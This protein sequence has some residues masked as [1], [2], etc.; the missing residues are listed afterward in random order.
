MAPKRNSLNILAIRFSAIGDVA[1]TVPV[2]D[3]FARQYPQHRITFLS[4]PRFEPFFKSMPANFIFLGADVK[5]EYKGNAGLRRLIGELCQRD[6]DLVLDLHGVLRSERIGL[7]MFLHGVRIKRIRKDRLARK[8][9]TRQHFKR[10]VPLQT[11]FERYS[12]VF[13]RA[14]FPVAVDF[15]SFFSEPPVE[16]LSLTGSKEGRWI[17]VAP[18]AAHKGKIYPL[19][20]MEKVI[21]NLQSDAQVSRIFVFAYGKE[22]EQIQHWAGLY[23]KV[24]LSGGRYTF[25]QELELM[26]WLDVMLA[27]D[28]ANMHL[29]SLVGTRVVSVWGATHPSA[30]FLGYGQNS[31]DCVQLDLSCRPCSIYGKKACRYGDCRCMTGISPE[32]ILSRLLK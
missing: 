23:S 25:S 17:G 32:S 7:G 1:M 5:N 2:L 26:Y 16:V 24:E 29:A 8:A 14:G 18:F 21:S 27:M 3:S 19:E 15:K 11:S 20:L 6:F 31:D 12:K 22:K 10:Y 28:S 30:G 4:N 13:E 9:L